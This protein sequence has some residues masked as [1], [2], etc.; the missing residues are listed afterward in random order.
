[1]AALPLLK[2]LFI[3]T[4]FGFGFFGD[5]ANTNRR[6]DSPSQVRAFLSWATRPPGDAV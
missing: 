1:M 2:G 4:H 5:V 3:L 6:G